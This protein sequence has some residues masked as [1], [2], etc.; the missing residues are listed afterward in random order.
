MASDLIGLGHH[1]GATAAPHHEEL[2]YF[3]DLQQT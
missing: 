1:S 3:S 2:P